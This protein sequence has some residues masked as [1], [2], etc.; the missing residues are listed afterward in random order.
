MRRPG[1]L[2]RLLRSLYIAKE[3]E[4]KKITVI[5]FVNTT[6]SLAE[7]VVL[8]ARLYNAV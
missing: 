4:K 2:Y 6:V 7:R 1:V 3:E 8:R 5:C